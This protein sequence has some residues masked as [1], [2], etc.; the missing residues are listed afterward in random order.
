MLN[1]TLRHKGLRN[2]LVEE[3]VSKG[4]TDKSVLE[5]IRTVPRHLFMELSFDPKIAYMDNAV[6][7]AREQTISRPFTVAFQTQLLEVSKKEKIL[8][9]G[10]GSGYQTA[11]LCHLKAEVYTIERQRQLFLSAK[12]LL[13]SLGYVAKSFFSDGYR[14]LTAFAPYDKIL[15]TCGAPQVPDELIRQLKVGGSMVIPIG[16]QTQ[17]MYKIIKK[18]ETEIETL[19]FGDCK[20]VPMLEEKE[21][22]L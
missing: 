1:D 18:S 21:I 12:S 2:K 9:I 8:E 16:E 3:L 5:A 13:H 10:T 11:V 19:N 20:F 6:K 7:I 22:N 4:I 14:G 15:V 17:T